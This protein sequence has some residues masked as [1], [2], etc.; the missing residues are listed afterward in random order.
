MRISRSLII[1][2]SFL[3]LAIFSPETSAQNP[4]NE[5]WNSFIQWNPGKATLPED[6]ILGPLANLRNPDPLW[7]E[8]L[9][10]CDDVF[11]AIRDGRVPA[12]R[13]HPRVRIPLSLEFENVLVDG[14]KD[15]YPRYSVPEYE[16][17]QIILRVRLA[18]G[19]GVQL[20]DGYIYLSNWEGGWFIDRWSQNFSEYPSTGR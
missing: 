13:I 12:E 3:S 8:A 6:E 15:V 17:G 10:V 11:S 7:A 18:D 14:G 20:S 5:L 16:D 1:V 2:L 9:R 4:D 19:E